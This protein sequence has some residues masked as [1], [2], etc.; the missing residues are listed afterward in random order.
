[1]KKLMLSTALV[2][3]TALT[4]AAQDA[5][6]DSPF[7]TAADPLAIHA[8]A[9][10]GK[11]VYATQA[12]L[13][14]EEYA[15]R[16][17]GWEDIGEINDVVLTRDGR[18]DAVLVDIGGFL[19]MG[20]RQVAV[21]MS[22]IRFV[23]DSATPEDLSDYLLVMNAG[24]NVFEGA[25]DYSRSSVPLTG[26]AGT[27]LPAATDATD[28]PRDDYAAA[29]RATL[30]SAD[31]VGARVYDAGDDWIGSVD[32]LLLTEGGQITSAVVDVGG[33][34]GIGAKPVVLAM[35]DLTILRAQD[36][37]NVVV[38]VGMTREQLDA[39]PRFDG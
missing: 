1:M 11:R 21:H 25:P 30:T 36:G 6:M 17:D 28:M 4:A 12:A 37:S 16:Q 14:A 2:A 22:A 35:D 33:F 5:A 32:R 24:R 23:A 13:D 26:S 19:G 34:L 8:S 20:E 7:L 39:L 10:I 15:G 18:V 9:F 27:S 38:S 29:D 31:L 3:A